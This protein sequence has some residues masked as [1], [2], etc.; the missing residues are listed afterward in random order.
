MDSGPSFVGGSGNDTFNASVAVNTGTGVYDVETLSA[1][2][3]IDGGA[4]TDTLNYTTVGGT[5]LPAATLTSI[6]LINVVSD[7][8]VT[9]DVQNASS[10]TTLTAKAVANAVDIDTKGNATSVTV[11]GTATTVAIDDNGATG[12]DKLAT[13][14]ITGNTGNVTIG[15]NAS[16]DTLT[17]LTLINSVNGDAT[18][19]AAAGTRALALTLNGVTG[20]GNNVVITDDTATTLTITGTGALSSAI[21][22]QADAATTISIAADEKITFAAIDASAATTLTVTGDSLVTFTTN[23]AADLGALTTVN[24]SGNT[25]GLSLGTEL[26]TGVTF[27]GSSAADSVK[28]GATTKTITMGDGNDTVTLSANVGTGGTIDAGAGTADVLSLT[29][30]LAANDSLSASTTFEGKISGFERLALTTVTGS[31]TVDL[32]NLDDISWVTTTAATAL[33]LD[34]MTSGGTVQITAAST[35]VTVNV[36]DAALGGHN[37]DVLNIEL[38]AATSGGNVDYGALTAAAVETIN[39]NSTRSGTVV[40]ADTNEIDLTIANVVTL[41]VTGDVLADLDGAALAGNA[42]ATVNASTNTGG[43]KV[44]VTGASQGIAITGSATKANTMVGGSGGDVITGGSGVDTVDG[45]AGD[46]QI[47]GG[48]G[49]DVITGGTGIDTIDLGSGV[50]GDTV[51]YGAANTLL[52]A[53]RDVITNFT[54]GATTADTVTI[55]A[56]SIVDTT[57]AAGAGAA[58]A[59]QFKT[60]SSTLAAGAATFTAT[61]YDADTGWVMEIATTL[62]SNGDLSLTSAAGLNGTELLKALSSTTTASTGIAFTDTTDTGAEATA[63]YI[64]A[65]QN[66]KAYLYYA[67]D[68]DNSNSYEATEIALIGTFNGVTAG[69]FTFDNIV[70]A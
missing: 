22:L 68:A 55:L 10:V 21:D 1:L 47:S 62:S 44:T 49:A 11:T 28:L 64:I 25:G 23:T 34:K 67:A 27:T 37:T 8:A 16:T 45:G 15:A 53:N 66:D 14:S 60:I 24:A 48:A 17:S 59:T 5:A 46:D 33:T 30:A 29:E 31:K 4:G 61:G 26:A 43:L 40:A 58:T 63:G 42:L 18:V 65:Y 50:A 12:A 39:V 69:A 2:D 52:A 3:I 35:A 56:A 6:E 38:K 7:G 9:A 70:A 13:V 20:P 19:T 57:E 36:T 54:A 32:A 51:K 41:N